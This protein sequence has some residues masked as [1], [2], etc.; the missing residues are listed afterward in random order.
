MNSMNM[1]MNSMNNI[2]YPSLCIGLVFCI[3]TI[4]VIVFGMGKMSYACIQLDIIPVIVACILYKKSSFST[5]SI[6]S[7]NNNVNHYTHHNTHNSYNNEIIQN[8]VFPL[9]TVGYLIRLLWFT[10]IVMNQLCTK[11]K[12]RPFTIKQ[13]QEQQKAQ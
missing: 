12:I 8:L 11:L 3:I 13:K 6:L 1:N 2:R 9:L 7:N 4:K 5:T 10:S